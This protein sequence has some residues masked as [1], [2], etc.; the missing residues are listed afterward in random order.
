MFTRVIYLCS[1]HIWHW[2]PFNVSRPFYTKTW[3]ALSWTKYAL[4]QMSLRVYTGCFHAKL[5]AKLAFVTYPWARWGLPRLRGGRVDVIQSQ[6]LGFNLFWG[7][8]WKNPVRKRKA[9]ALATA[10]PTTQSV[11]FPLWNK[12]TRMRRGEMTLGSYGN[13]HPQQLLRLP[14]FG[15]FCSHPSGTAACLVPV[16]SP[17]F[18]IESNPI[19]QHPK[20]MLPCILDLVFSPKESTIQENKL[21]YINSDNIFLYR[22]GGS[23]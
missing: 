3:K 20:T 1:L 4:M 12:K 8:S 5:C 21:Y 14:R 13:Q 6:H 9:L 23:L 19:P 2:S 7:E 22:F 18:L 11:Q 15:E 17:I 16:C 10:L